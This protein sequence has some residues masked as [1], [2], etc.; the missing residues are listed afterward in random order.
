MG[1]FLVV[2][3]VASLLFAA[4]APASDGSKPAA[5]ADEREIDDLIREY[6][7]LRQRLLKA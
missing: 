4:T 7:T 1:R 3:A 2:G 6:D 5:S